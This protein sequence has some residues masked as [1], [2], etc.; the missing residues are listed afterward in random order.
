M[1][2]RELVP[3]DVLQLNPEHPKFPG[4]LSYAL[5]QNHGDAKAIS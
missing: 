3:G 4:C 2:K 5:S 1:E